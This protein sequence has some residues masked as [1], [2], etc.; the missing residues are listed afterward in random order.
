MLSMLLVGFLVNIG[1]LCFSGK[2]LV[3]E[4]QCTVRVYVVRLRATML[5][6]I[7]ISKR[8]PRETIRIVY[9][10]RPMCVLR[11]AVHKRNEHTRS[12]DY[13]LAGAV[14]NAYVDV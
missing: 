11:A 6:W 4:R 10:H 3:C 12:Y 9:V 5:L 13:V 2:Y 14:R 8:I 7:F 1:V